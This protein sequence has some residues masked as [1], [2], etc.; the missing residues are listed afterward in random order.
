MREAEAS[1]EAL[2]H[3]ADVEH[4]HQDAAE[5]HQLMTEAEQADR[6]AEAARAAAEH[7]PEHEPDP[8]ERDRAQVAAET[9]QARADHTRA[10][11]RATYDSA[12]RREAMAQG[13]ESRGIDH[14]TVATRMRA[15]VSQAKP[16]A[17]ATKTN[18][19]TRP[20]KARSTCGRA[21]QVQRTAKGPS[22]SD[23]KSLGTVVGG[24]W[25]RMAGY[26]ACVGAVA[27]RGCRGRGAAGAVGCEL[28][29]PRRIRRPDHGRR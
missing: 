1:A 16:A 7:E 21:P 20:R 4:N 9:E 15:D 12:E 6:N 18:A 26:G 3:G 2:R 14:E 10:D 5:A 25:A 29:R 22:W 23:E 8:A 11:G 24:C 28:P 13:L 27:R 19:S 17:A